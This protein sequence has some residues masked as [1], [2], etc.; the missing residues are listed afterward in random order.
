MT[1]AKV[2]PR[3]YFASRVSASDARR[4]RKL[5]ARLSC[6]SNTIDGLLLKEMIIA[7][8]DLL[9][10][11]REAM[12]ALNVFPVPDGDTGTNMSLT[13]KSAVKEM[14]AL[15]ECRAP[16]KLPQ[17]GRPRRAQGRAR[18]L[19]RHPLPDSARLCARAWTGRRPSTAR[20]VRDAALEAGAE[21]AYKAV[22]KPKEGTILTVVR[23]IAEDA[24][25]MLVE[26]AGRPAQAAGS[27]V[28]SQRRGHSE[29]DPGHAA[30]RSSRRAWS[31]P[32]DRVC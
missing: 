10:Q 13:M 4:V 5:E 18:Q 15:D 31:I 25:A 22:M 7:G 1:G 21:T 28:I 11:N 6:H 17:H 16:A 32:A 23:V 14:S 29:K 19:R 3:K 24:G 8:A 30:L 9:E 20:H 2:A 12:D 27:S 26:H